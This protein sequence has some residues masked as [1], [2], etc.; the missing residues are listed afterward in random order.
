[1]FTNTI[2]KKPTIIDNNGNEII[3]LT[4]SIFSKGATGLNSY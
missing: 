4:K 1:M 3:D 2:D